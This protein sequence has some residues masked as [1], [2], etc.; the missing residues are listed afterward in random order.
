MAVLLL[1]PGPTLTQISICG[2]FIL[3]THNM[4]HLIKFKWLKW[5]LGFAPISVY[6]FNRETVFCCRQT[7]TCPRG[8]A[9]H[10]TENYEAV[11]KYAT[12]DEKVSIIS[13]SSHL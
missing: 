5:N 4:I 1:H 12:S 9:C 6:N 10:M 7:L 8:P 13:E 2:A 11:S 3:V